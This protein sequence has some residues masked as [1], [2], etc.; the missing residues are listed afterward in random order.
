MVYPR[1]I[2][3][4]LDGLRAALADD[5]VIVHCPG[6]TDGGPGTPMEG[7]VLVHYLG[8]DGAELLQEIRQTV[9]ILEP[10]GAINND[11]SQRSK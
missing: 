11:L 4:I 1:R 10:I 8:A 2:V 5:V 3:Q 9:R 6:A 7:P